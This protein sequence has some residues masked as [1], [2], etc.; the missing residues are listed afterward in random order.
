MNS[1]C[2][3]AQNRWRVTEWA[4]ND[5]FANNTP[6]ENPAG[7]GTFTYNLRFPGQY[8]DV[9]TGKHYNYF[10]DYDPGIGRYLDSD[11]IGLRGGSNTYLYVGGDPLYFVD[12]LGLLC[13][14]KNI[15]YR[16]LDADYVGIAAEQSGKDTGDRDIY[17]HWWYELSDGSSYGWWP[18]G[19]G[20]NLTGRP[21]CV[22]LH[23]GDKDPH[24]GKRS[25]WDI[26]PS[27][28]D[29]G[30]DC[31]TACKDKEKCLKKF[32]RDYSGNWSIKRNCHGFVDESAS[33]C[34]LTLS[35]GTAAM[36]CTVPA[37]RPF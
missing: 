34:G 17:G 29:C 27:V 36:Q 37:H 35:A 7:A 16:G 15:R 32:A 12:P 4:H 19:R 5:P 18:C 25:D 1:I 3:I 24:G 11:P 30:G 9:E 20:S 13:T 10:R 2:S 6:N 31:E 26:H 21:G 8:Y 33:S 22:N 28:L 23:Q 14:C